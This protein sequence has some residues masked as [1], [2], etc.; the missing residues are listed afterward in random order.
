MAVTVWFID[1]SWVLIEKLEYRT[2]SVNMVQGTNSNWEVGATFYI[3]SRIFSFN[4]SRII[5]D[6]FSNIIYMFNISKEFYVLLISANSMSLH[7][8]KEYISY[9]FARKCVKLVKICNALWPELDT[10]FYCCFLL[11][12]LEL[13]VLDS[14]FMHGYTAMEVVLFFSLFALVERVN[15]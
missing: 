5:K 10:C 15:L 14:I 11:I 12:N 4:R 2:Y 1:E 3:K 6:L 8:Y 7:F 9:L 13:I